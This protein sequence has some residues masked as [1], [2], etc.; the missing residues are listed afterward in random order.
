[1]RIVKLQGGLGNQMFQYAFA[2]SLGDDVKFDVSWFLKKTKFTASV[3]HLKIGLSDFN[4]EVSVASSEEI[5]NCLNEDCFTN[6]LLP[7]KKYF[8]LDLITSNRMYERI[9]NDFYPSFYEMKENVYFDGYFQNPLYFT[10]IKDTLY[11]DFSLRKGLSAKGLDLIDDIAHSNSVA[12]SVRHAA[13]YEQL[14]W[15]LSEDYYLAAIAYLK[16]RYSNL[17]FYVFADN[18]DW[19]K[20]HFASEQNIRFCDSD[21]ENCGYAAGLFFM[22]N[23]RHVI[24]ANSS[25]S[26][27]AGYLNKSQ[28]VVVPN[29]WLP[30]KQNAFVKATFK[31]LYLP[32]WITMEDF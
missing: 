7:L 31:Q 16:E 17:K 32:N 22:A 24:I 8:G 12:I 1:M 20:K 18:L 28:S 5:R 6:L 15:S 30:E 13:D 2:K 29:H 9:R 23:C 19:C 25:Y 3:N 14:G 4:T 21:D 11:A 27:W 26:W 10:Q